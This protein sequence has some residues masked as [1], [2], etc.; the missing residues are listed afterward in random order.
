MNDDITGIPGARDP[1]EPRLYLLV[2]EDINMPAGK[3]Y[4]QAGHAFLGVV[5]AARRVGHPGIET[6]LAGQQGKIAVR[7]KNLGAIERAARECREAGLPVCV[8]TDA[9]RTV[10]GEPTVTCMAVGP[11]SRSKLP[12]FVERMRL[13]D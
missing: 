13:M 6:Y 10:F 5:E 4:A 11:V 3:G 12:K 2:R 7:A 8:V 9:G 1:E